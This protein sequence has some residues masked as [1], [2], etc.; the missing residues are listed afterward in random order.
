MVE[1]PLIIIK[2]GHIEISKSPKSL[3]TLKSK[4]ADN[5]LES[6]NKHMSFQTLKATGSSLKNIQVGIDVTAQN[7]A[8]VNTIGYKQQRVNFESIVS[9]FGETSYSGTSVNSITS[10]F[11]DG[12][13]KLTGEVTDLSIKGN[14]FF[15][16]ESPS[17]DIA[18]SRAGH[19][20]TDST[21]NL[22]DPNGY[23]V[24]SAG[25]GRIN[26]PQNAKIEVTSAG[27]IRALMQG[28]TEY[29][30]V[31]QLQIATFS[32]PQSLQNIGNNNYKES[33][34]SGT[35]EFVTALMSGTSAAETT[36]TS[37]S[38]E[39]S[40]AELSSSFTDLITFQRSYQ[41]V[42]KAATTANEILET[43]INLV[44]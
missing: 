24:L 31:D 9:T 28:E 42:S 13:T 17:G 19:F 14:G 16:L 8:N 4:N 25:G 2:L 21:G 40:N 33:I 43:T 7:I 1:N 39:T 23:F 35:P 22:V 12:R 36:V 10:D 3:S 20:L 5:V 41:S 11:S 44:R 32:N 29:Q 18:F 34:N 26:I 37:G 38:L 6:Q 27:E 30:L 15:S